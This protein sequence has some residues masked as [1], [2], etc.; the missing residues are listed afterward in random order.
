ML[1]LLALDGF[2][3]GLDFRITHSIYVPLLLLLLLLLLS[4][5][6]SDLVFLQ[7]LK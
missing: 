7:G 6:E 1:Y 5:S 2:V 3:L 4:S